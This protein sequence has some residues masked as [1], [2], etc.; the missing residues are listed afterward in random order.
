MIAIVLVALVGG[1]AAA[2]AA[3]LSPFDG[4]LQRHLRRQMAEL[5]DDIR[6]QTPHV[7]ETFDGDA[8]QYTIPVSGF[9]D[10]NDFN[11]SARRGTLLVHAVHLSNSFLLT[12]RLPQ[13]ASERATW[14]YD[15]GVLR[16]TVPAK[17]SDGD[18]ALPTDE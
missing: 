10:V 5:R 9:Q 1:A 3:D 6:S 18:A 14:T 7:T 12:Q 17:R 13:F 11:V 15:D 16:V 8:L 2:P 4:S